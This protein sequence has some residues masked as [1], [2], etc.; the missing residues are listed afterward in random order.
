MSARAA[1]T[2]ASLMNVG[3]RSASVRV[4]RSARFWWR[5]ATRR[6]GRPTSRKRRRSR[7]NASTKGKRRTKTTSARTSAPSEQ[8]PSRQPEQQEEPADVRE[9]GH[10]D[11]RGDGGV[12]AEP[13][14]DDRDEPARESRHEQVAGHR[15]EDDDAEA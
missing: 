9:G 13:L 7:R 4:S 2:W 5:S 6:R 11:R 3:P 10:E 12:D 1:K 8:Q 14:Q 15:Q